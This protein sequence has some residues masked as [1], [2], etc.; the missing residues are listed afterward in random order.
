MKTSKKFGRTSQC[1]RQRKRLSRSTT[2]NLLAPFPTSFASRAHYSQPKNETSNAPEAHPLAPE[3]TE[4]TAAA[5]RKQH[6]KSSQ[7]ASQET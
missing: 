6:A 3:S 4:Q 5:Q 7:T 1:F 2:T